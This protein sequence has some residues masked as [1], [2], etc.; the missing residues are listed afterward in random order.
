MAFGDPLA[1]LKLAIQATADVLAAL[2]ASLSLQL[3]PISAQVSASLDAAAV[4]EV[5]IG[6]INAA[7]DLALAVKLG[8]VN[9]LAQLDAALSLGGVALYYW[10]DIATS[11]LQAQ[12]AAHN[13]GAEGF[14]PA[15]LTTGVMLVTK[16]PGASASFNFL[17]ALPP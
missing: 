7:I 5:K 10:R 6:G 11:T 1:Q 8:A 14:A 9:F 4:L 15:D 2:Q 16:T 12:I 3:P 13:F 17:F